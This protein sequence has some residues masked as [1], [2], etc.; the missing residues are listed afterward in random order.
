MNLFYSN[1]P[2]YRI[3]RHIIFWVSFVMLY[4]FVYGVFSGKFYKKFCYTML[5][6]PVMIPAAYSFIYIVE[7][8]FYKKRYKLFAIWFF[9]SVLLFSYLYIV[10]DFEVIMKYLYDRDVT[11]SKLLYTPLGFIRVYSI[12]ILAFMLKLLRDHIITREKNQNL[13]KER[14]K[15]ELS[16]LKSQIHPHFLFNTL[17]NL[18]SLALAK[19]DNTAEGI[20]K[21][22]HI[23]KY[24]VYNEKIQLIPL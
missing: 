15:S 7:K 4:T 20:M 24:I 23:L 3:T 8:Y 10:I 11:K 13:E 9:V 21:L 14:L 17:N 6:L 12:V 22:S 2:K 5:L 19:S 16:F 1:K 18:Y